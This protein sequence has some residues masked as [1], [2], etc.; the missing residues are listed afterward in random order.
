MNMGSRS[1]VV[2]VRHGLCWYQKPSTLTT[3]SQGLVCFSLAP[4]S[5]M[6]FLFWHKF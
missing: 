5:D 3:G 6:L 1:H 2:C 4:K